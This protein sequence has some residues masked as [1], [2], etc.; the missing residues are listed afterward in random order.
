MTSSDHD[1]ETTTMPNLFYS[2]SLSLSLSTRELTTA[3]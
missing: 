1:D 2:L 3:L